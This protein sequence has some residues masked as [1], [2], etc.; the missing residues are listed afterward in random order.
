MLLMSFEDILTDSFLSLPCYFRGYHGINLH[1]MTIESIELHI[2]RKEEC[3]KQA[4]NQ[5]RPHEGERKE[6]KFYLWWCE[7]NTEQSTHATFHSLPCAM[8]ASFRKCVQLSL[9]PMLN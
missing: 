7:Q 6:K 2:Q 9:E 4:K 1:F 8:H 5:P 3:L